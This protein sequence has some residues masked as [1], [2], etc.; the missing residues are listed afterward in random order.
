MQKNT[1]LAASTYCRISVFIRLC[2]CV[3]L[4][5]TGWSART[6]RLL[7]VQCLVMPS[8]GRPKAA[9]QP[10]Q[11]GS[12]TIQ[13]VPTQ[14]GFHDVAVSYNDAPVEGQ[15]L[16]HLW[17][18][19]QKPAPIFISCI[20]IAWHKI[21]QKLVPNICQTTSHAG[22]SWFI[23]QTNRSTYLRRLRL[24]CCRAVL[25]IQSQIYDVHKY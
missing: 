9:V 2:A 12:V 20:V 3:C 19:L 22:T 1:S 10:N 14:S 6:H 24:K 16:V 17:R 8:A 21:T 7:S 11:D 15:F 4:I 5:G 18:S 25:L 13:Y 23:S